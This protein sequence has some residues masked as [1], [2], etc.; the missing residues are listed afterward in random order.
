MTRLGVGAAVGLPLKDELG[1]GDVVVRVVWVYDGHAVCEINPVFVIAYV[2]C[3]D[4]ETLMETEALADEEML[5]EEEGCAE[6]L[7]DTYG[8]ADAE[9]LDVW[10][11]GVFMELTESIGGAVTLGLLTAVKVFTAV[12][13]AKSV[14]VLGISIN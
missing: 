11:L 13:L 8:D 2:G 9:L 5:A 12:E 1:R 4:D 6:G 7:S 14:R 3:A 10:K